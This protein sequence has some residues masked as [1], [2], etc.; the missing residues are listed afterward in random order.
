MCLYIIMYNFIY[1]R[2]IYVSFYS[3]ISVERKREVVGEGL[4]RPSGQKKKLEKQEEQLKNYNRDLTMV[5][6]GFHSNVCMYNYSMYV[7]M[8]VSIYIYMYVYRMI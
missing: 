3:S 1:M 6:T 5:M 8:Y 7:C 2:Y 4:A